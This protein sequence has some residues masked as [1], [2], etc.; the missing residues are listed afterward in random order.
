MVD[1]ISLLT[2]QK[3]SRDNPNSTYSINVLY[4][5]IRLCLKPIRVNPNLLTSSY[6]RV[7][8]KAHVKLPPLHTQTIS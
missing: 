2:V 7:R 1:T 8:L 3:G 5:F 4:G 6:F